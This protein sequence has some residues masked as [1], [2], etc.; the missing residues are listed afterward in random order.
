MRYNFLLGLVLGP[1]LASADILAVDLGSQFFKVALVSTGKFE[2]VPNLQSKRK[3]PLAM[4]T[5]SKSREF[6]DDALLAQAKSPSKVPTFFRWLTGANLTAIPAENLYPHEFTTPFV[7]SQDNE[8]L[9]PLFGNEDFGMRPVEDILSHILWYSKNLVEEHDTPSTGRAKMGSLKDLVITVPSWAT[10]RQRQAVVDAASIAGFSKVSLVHETSAAAVQRAFD[11]NATTE[12]NVMY[13]N[14]GAGH[15][16]ACIV[17]YG[18]VGKGSLEAPTVKMLGCSYSL[19]AGG[20]EITANLAKLGA[21]AFLR[22]HEKADLTNEPTA[23]VR[24]FRQAENVKYT[25][26]ANKETLFSVESIWDEKDLKLHVTRTDVEKASEKV[27]VEIHKVV[28]ETLDR[29]NVTKADVHQIEVIGGGWR[30]P[31]IQENL[32]KL[33]SPLPLGQHLNGDEAMVFGA[34]FISANASSSFRVRKVLFTD[35]TENDYSIQITPKTVPDGEESKWPRTQSIFPVGHKLGSTKAIKVSVN[36]DLDVDV[37]EN[38]NLIESMLVHGSRNESS[39]EVPQIVLKVKLDSSGLF[40][41]AGAEAV[42]ERMEE[43][44]IKVPL[45]TTNDKNETEY[46]TTTISVPRKTKINLSI[47]S[48]F[49]AKPLAM[50][51]DHIKTSRENL[52]TIVKA[53]NAIKLRTKT[54]NDLEALIY[55]MN[56]KMDDDALVK[57][58]SS[59]EERSAVLAAS[60]HAEEWLD[61]NGYSASVDEFKQ[62]IDALKST[63]KPIYDRIDEERKQIEEE[64]R[65]RKLQAELERLAKLNETI[66]ANNTTAETNSTDSE[67]NAHTPIPELSDEGTTESVEADEISASNETQEATDAP[68]EEL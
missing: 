31:H 9:S 1:L 2:I 61:D 46:N 15:F 10:R 53:E 17:Q 14:M 19:K 67:A 58:H 42:Y 64:H 27:V 57:K 33:F 66:A 38:G 3:T 39:S 62:Q 20:S 45:N 37:F 4:S 51:E 44:T 55:S 24:L 47:D 34:A 49:E 35:I 18:L 54:K 11:V 48:T 40:D 43:Q 23:M 63:A 52:K 60:K 5:K 32:E 28:S 68:I 41:V 8:R 56:D 6:G 36:S 22:K 21:E 25:L 59:P 16:E 30:V 7:V 65:L 29:C 12:T 13:L 26:S 50:S